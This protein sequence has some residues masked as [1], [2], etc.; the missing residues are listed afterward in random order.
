MKVQPT[1]PMK[2]AKQRRGKSSGVTKKTLEKKADKEKRWADLLKRKP[3]SKRPKYTKGTKSFKHYGGRIHYSDAKSAY[4]VYV[5]KGDK[6]E[7][8]IAVNKEE[9]KDFQTKLD[10]SCAIIEDDARPRE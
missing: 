7:V 4:R 2:A 3:K 10:L 6:V 9:P 5:R 1:Q 8:T